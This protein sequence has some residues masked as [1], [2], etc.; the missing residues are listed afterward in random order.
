MTTAVSRA[1]E[2]ALGDTTNSFTAV[3]EEAAWLEPPGGPL[4]GLPIAVKDLIDHAG[5]VTTAGSAF[6]RHHATTTAPAVARLEAAGAVVIGR[7]GLHEFAFGFSSENPW[8]GPVLNPW[9]HRLSPGGSSGGSAAAVAAGIVPVALGTDTGGSVRVPAALCGI[10]GLKT[11]HGLIPLD[12]VFPLVPS[13]DTVGPLAATLDDI[14]TTTAVMAAHRWETLDDGPPIRRLVVPQAWLDTAPMTD[15]VRT[16]FSEFLDAAAWV[17]LVVEHRELS[18]LQPSPHQTALVGAEV[19]LIH[20]KWREEGKPYGEDVAARIDENVELADDPT[21]QAEARKWREQITRAMTEATAG[22]AAVVT[23]AVG[24]MDKWI[25]DDRIE[26]HHYRRVLSWFSAPVNPTGQPALAMPIAG[27]G[28][29]PAVQLI[30]A[31]GSEKRLIGLGRL[32]ETR[33]V[34]GVSRLTYG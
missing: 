18:D 22:D 32:L 24:A 5:H 21:A 4:H 23:P 11:T 1:L 20:R 10:I 34:L 26:G 6:Y 15:E 9:D 8:F 30:G 19:A 28:R 3:H 13:F 17:G 14:E 2:K 16:A 27:P 33:G 29:R 25:G 7:T 31:A 12:G